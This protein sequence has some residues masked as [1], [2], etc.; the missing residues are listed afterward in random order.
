MAIV[1]VHRGIPA[2]SGGRRPV[3]RLLTLHRVSLEEDEGPKT[4]PC[5]EGPR[6]TPTLP[7][8]G[9]RLR[10]R[11]QAPPGRTTLRLAGGEAVAR[12]VPR[13]RA[14]AGREM[15]LIEARLRRSA[16]LPK[17]DVTIMPRAAEPQVK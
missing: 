14:R 15:K 7:D 4:C 13:W 2:R 3:R 17:Y 11:G 16:T 9:R 1:A 8:R 6:V 12:R 10:V 5:P